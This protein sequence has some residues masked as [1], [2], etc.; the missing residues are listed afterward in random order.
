MLGIL[1]GTSFLKAEPL[2]GCQ[3]R[4]ISTLYGVC[5]LAVTDSIV[6]VP[7]HGRHGYAPPH[8]I[9]HQA[10]IFAMKQ[11]GVDRIVSF[12]SSGSLKQEIQPGNL[13]VP[14]D[15]FAPFRVMTFQ[16]ENLEYIVP[17][18]DEDWRRNVIESLHQAGMSVTEEGV[19]AETLGPRFETRAE[20]RFLQQ[21]ADL[22]GMTCAAETSL[23]K[24]L[25]IPHTIVCTVDNYAHGIGM[26]PL[27]GHEFEKMVQRNR[28]L[29]MQAFHVVATM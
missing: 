10:H 5:E 24:E 3:W 12:G 8:T 17:G 1:G 27:T 15:Y 13:V 29:S 9:N 19:Y 18:F 6:Y 20:I 14:D 21:A 16:E 28:D 25:A 22:V 23:A 4:E 11:Q 26:E 2:E 7:R